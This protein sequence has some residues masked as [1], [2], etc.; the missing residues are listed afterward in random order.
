MTLIGTFS[1]QLAHNA[2]GAPADVLDLQGGRHTL[3]LGA[4]TGTMFV[5]HFLHHARRRF[6]AAESVG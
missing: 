5:A 4:E 3:S 6:Q 2:P 1:I